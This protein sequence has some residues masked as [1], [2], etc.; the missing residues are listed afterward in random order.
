MLYAGACVASKKA[1]TFLQ[2]G[3]GYHLILTERDGAELEEAVKV[4]EDAK[5]DP[6]ID[7]VYEFTL[8][9]VLAAFDKSI[10]GRAKGK[11]VVKIH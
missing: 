2:G 11:I 8:P 10:S 9:S 5:V 3:P 7:S 6:T 1:I 4:L